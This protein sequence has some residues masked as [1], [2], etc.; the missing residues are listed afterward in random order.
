MRQ[1][2]IGHALPID[3]GPEMVAAI[4]RTGEDA[5]ELSATARNNG[6]CVLRVHIDLN[7]HAHTPRFIDPYFWTFD[8]EGRAATQRDLEDLNRVGYGE[9]RI[10]GYL[11]T[12]SPRRG[13]ESG[14]GR[15][16]VAPLNP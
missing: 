2:P 5:C 4:T 3:L 8:I 9:F 13:R 15:G 12:P 16:P 14:E 6:D 11:F 7:T 10:D 1:I